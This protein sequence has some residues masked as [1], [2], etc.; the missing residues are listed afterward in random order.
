MNKEV[1]I[2]CKIR[3]KEENHDMVG[4][5]LLMYVASARE[6]DGRLYYH[7]FEN[8]NDKVEFYILDRWN[9]MNAVNAHIIHP[10]VPKIKAILEPYLLEKQELTW[11]SI[12]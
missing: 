12:T 1:R 10:N 9:D 2:I 4:K 5:I 6:E 8:C 3:C 11:C 7:I